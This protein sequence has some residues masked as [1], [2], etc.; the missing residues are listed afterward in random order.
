MGCIGFKGLGVQGSGF[1]LSGLRVA[2]FQGFADGIVDF[3][4]AFCRCLNL[5]VAFAKVQVGLRLDALGS[6]A[7]RLG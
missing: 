5:S 6:L 1:G 7:F 3:S 4:A 2:G